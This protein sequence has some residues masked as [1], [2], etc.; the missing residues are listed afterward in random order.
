MLKIERFYGLSPRK[1]P[2]RPIE[3]VSKEFRGGPEAMGKYRDY[4]MDYEK[5]ELKGTG[6]I[7]GQQI[8]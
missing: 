1:L 2:G 8:W 4:S 7:K 5:N 6:K 3:D